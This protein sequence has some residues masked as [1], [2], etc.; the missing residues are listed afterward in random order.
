V[1]AHRDLFPLLHPNPAI[2]VNGEP[3]IFEATVF[4]PKSATNPRQLIFVDLK[5]TSW[6][7]AGNELF[8]HS[9]GFGMQTAP[10]HSVERRQLHEPNSVADLQSLPF[11]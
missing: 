3:M 1:E 4:A 8:V 5:D 9:H 10:R 6:P 7:A 2:V 11:G